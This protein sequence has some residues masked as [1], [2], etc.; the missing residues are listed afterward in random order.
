MF[1]ILKYCTWLDK[2]WGKWQLQSH[3]GVL[4][5]TILIFLLPD[6]LVSHKELTRVVKYTSVLYFVRD[7]WVPVTTARHVRR[8][9]MEEL[10]PVRRVAANILNKQWRTAYKGWSSSWEFGEVL[11][12]PYSK[13]RIVL[14]NINREILWPGLILRFVLRIGTGGGH[15][16]MR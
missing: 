3:C 8:L 7:Q 2:T 12:N 5:R 6:S 4:H 10:P 16:W 15:L 9:R 13:K 11:T 14:W 1:R